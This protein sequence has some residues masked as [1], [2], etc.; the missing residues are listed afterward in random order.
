MSGQE[1]AKPKQLRVVDDS[2]ETIEHLDFEQAI[3]CEAVLCA[4]TQ[5]P[6]PAVYLIQAIQHWLIPPN[7][8]GIVHGC[9]QK[10]WT[11]LGEIDLIQC[12]NCG[13]VLGPRDEVFKIVEVLK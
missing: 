7:M 13:D 4:A 11:T 9:C 8:V 10:C 6:R 3:P 1:Q 5:M 12:G 2:P